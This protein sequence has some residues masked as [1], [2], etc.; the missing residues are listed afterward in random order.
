MIA[1]ASFHRALEALEVGDAGL[2][3]LQMTVQIVAILH[4]KLGVQ[5]VRKHREDLFATAVR[6]GFFS[7]LR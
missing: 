3:T 1:A 6:H 5:V 4:R 2:A 7:H